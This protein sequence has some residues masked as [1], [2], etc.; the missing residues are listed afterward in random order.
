[1]AVVT[2]EHHKGDTLTPLAAQFQRPDG[3]AVDITGDTI[4]FKMIKISDG[5][6]KVA[7]TNT[8]VTVNNASTG[9]VQYDFQAADVDTA[10]E[11]K[12]YF[13]R[14]NSGETEHFPTKTRD[15]LVIIHGD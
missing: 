1:M 7:L 9:K 12:A 6:T 5:A 13:V 15:L 4:K 3:S 14:D 2:H 10:G 8:G 11:Y